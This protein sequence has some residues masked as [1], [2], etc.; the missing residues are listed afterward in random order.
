MQV[1]VAHPSLRVPMLKLLWL[2]YYYLFLPFFDLP[3]ALR[4]REL[5]NV[6]QYWCGPVAVHL[7][8][9]RDIHWLNVSTSLSPS[10]GGECPQTPSR[11]WAT[12]RL[13]I[14]GSGRLALRDRA[15]LGRRISASRL[16]TCTNGWR[17]MCPPRWRRWSGGVHVLNCFR[18]FVLTLL[19]SSLM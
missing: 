9:V 1:K 15:P 18:K 12:S 11:T 13:A 6:V 8:M 5:V 7:R 4:D 3:L 16:E 17:S 19:N 10:N 14:S 2:E